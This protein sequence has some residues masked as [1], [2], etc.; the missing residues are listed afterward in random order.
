[1][2]IGSAQRSARDSLGFPESDGNRHWCQRWFGPIPTEQVSRAQVNGQP[3]LSRI[4]SIGMMGED[5]LG[6][7][8]VPRPAADQGLPLIKIDLSPVKRQRGGRL[9]IG[10]RTGMTEIGGQ[11]DLTLRGRR[12][13]GRLQRPSPLCTASLGPFAMGFWACFPGPHQKSA[14]TRG[15]LYAQPLPARFKRNPGRR[16]CKRGQEGGRVKVER[17]RTH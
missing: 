10:D 7:T 5:C 9:R 11:N 2:G 3:R 6:L 14:G 17:V 16:I 8:M 4:D 15:V 1:M 12:R 13:R